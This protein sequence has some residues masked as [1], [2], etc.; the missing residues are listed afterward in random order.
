MGYWFYIDEADTDSK[1]TLSLL[2]EM[3][4]FELSGRVGQTPV[5]TIPVGGR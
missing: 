5:L 4:Q 3:S 2:L 1:S